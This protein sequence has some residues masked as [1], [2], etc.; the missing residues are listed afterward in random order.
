MKKV[1]FIFIFLSSRLISQVNAPSLRCL[2][3]VDSG[4]VILTWIPAQADPSGFHS[5]EIYT[6]L[7]KTGPFSLVPSTLTSINTNTFLHVRAVASATI[8]L[9]YYFVV[10]KYGA[11]GT[12]SSPN[13]DTLNT[14]FL[15]PIAA[16]PALKLDFVH[17]HSPKLPSSAGGYIINKEYP[18]G[19]TKVL[20]VTSGITYRDTIDVCSAKINYQVILPDASGCQSRSQLI[21]GEYED[22]K[23]PDEP[24]IDSI[25][26]LPN[27]NTVLAWQATV[28]KDVV[29][30]P[31][32]YAI[33]TQTG[34]KN[35]KIDSTMGR[36][37]T[38]Y[39]YTTTT[40]N[41]GSVGIFAQARDSCD[42]GS[43][44]NYQVR[45][46]FVEANY[47]RCAYKTSL[48]WNRYIWSAKGGVI[49][50][51][52]GKYK[53]YYSVNGSDFTVVGE[54]TDTN[55]VHSDVAPGKNICYFIRVVNKSATVT[56]SSNRTCFFSD[57]VSAPA[58]IYL[59]TATVV[60]KSSVEVRVYLDNT[61]SSQG[62]TIQRSD[63][64]LN[65][66][67]VGY[68]PF[69]GQAHYSF[70]DAN[71]QPSQ[72]SY[73]Y[74]CW[75]VDSCGNTRNPSNTAKTILLKVHSDE[76][77]IFT[78]KLSWSEYEGFGGAVSGYNV[79]R[80]I[81]DD[82]NGALI[83]S[84]DALTTTYTDDIEAAASQGAKIEYQVQAVEGIGNPYG[85]FENSSSNAVPVFMEGNLYVPNAFAPSG[86]NK[87]WLPVAYFIEKTEYHVS[88]F[89]RWGKKVFEANDNLTGWD[90]SDCISDVY[91]YLIDY[92]NARG[93]YL[94]V[95]GTV[96]LLR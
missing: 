47:N 78:K 7:S 16:I 49:L 29:K 48:R 12:T 23:D 96:M 87:I 52:L 76:D 61:K 42:K 32:Q 6:A 9:C 45:T 71:A 94:Q 64:G 56:S 15:N 38:F 8:Q 18:L 24:Y 89:N 28:D 11:S 82:L 59:K 25:S 90:G 67:N 95:K 57:Q 77:Q 5:Y 83:G 80:I 54:T 53:I 19:T 13:S 81:N 92:K 58:Y 44:V 39:V 79:Y 55:F 46:M 65:Y 1:L 31:I 26:V 10:A 63:D 62:I 51:S 2:E 60:D 73:Y 43:T 68:L 84:T 74:K 3:I 20:A 41:F 37:N 36:N 93:E 85:I 91:V 72:K 75:V 50:E 66:T 69:T 14:I 34:P 70:T 22:T 33:Q 86:V 88:V 21:R 35:V 40:A 17:L 27:G 30:Y 4:N